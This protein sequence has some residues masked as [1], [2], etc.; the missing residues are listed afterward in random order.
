M[1]AQRGSLPCSLLRWGIWYT[2]RGA[3]RLPLLGRPQRLTMVWTVVGGS[4]SRRDEM[5]RQL[6]SQERLSESSPLSESAYW[7]QREGRQV[8]RQLRTPQGHASQQHR[9]TVVRTVQCGAQD[10]ISACLHSRG[11]DP[12]VPGVCGVVAGTE[13]MSIANKLQPFPVWV[14]CIYHSGRD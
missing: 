7:G 6:S 5:S 14:S 2:L 4:C 1:V 10:L 12:Q 13:E 9:N 8:G 11:D 3:L